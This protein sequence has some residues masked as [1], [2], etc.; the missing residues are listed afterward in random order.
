MIV[1]AVLGVIGAAGWY[2]YRAFSRRNAIAAA[3]Q[4]ADRKEYLQAALAAKRALDFNPKDLSA[5]KLMA[6]MAEAVK[7]REA[8]V[9]RKTVAEMEPGV[10]ENYLQW[11]DTAI[12][13]RDA[14]SAR[15]ALSKMDAA[16]KNTSA[17]HDMAARLA[18]LAGQTRDVQGHVAEAARLDPKNESYQLQLAAVQLGSPL[19]EVRKAATATVEQL[20]ESPKVRRAALRVLVQSSLAANEPNTALKFAYRL[21]TGPDG[22]FEDRMLTLKILGMLQ[23]PE[24]W[25]FIGQ[26]GADLPENDED[27]VT[28]LSWLNNNRLPHLSLKWIGELPSDRV[29]RVPVCVAVAEAHALLGNWSKLKSVLKFQKWGELEFQREALVARVTR[30]EG[31]EAGSHSHW[32]AAV[33]LAAERRD[34]HAALARFA[35]AWKWE[36]EYTNLL[37]VIAKG[38]ND[39]MMALQKLLQKY[40]A[41]G[42]TREL[43]SVFNRMLELEPQNLNTKN[44]VAYALLILNMEPERAHMLANE[45]RSSDPSNSEFTTTYAL[46][47]HMKGKT[48]LALKAMQTVPEKEL[49]IPATALT[50]AVI[51]AAKGKDEEAREF[52]ALAETGTLVPQEKTILLK[53]KDRLPRKP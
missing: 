26:L 25:W 30:E 21:M 3:R 28:L 24:Y 31:D 5:N 18:V 42:N 6:E 17:Y 13:F 20:A 14:A 36:E 40:H 12:R 49:R 23:R 32:N 9:W 44:N 48:D 45:I 51:L 10:A 2:G 50:Y 41:D 7:T 43:L 29:E 53:T 37:W 16:G 8:V 34:A 4:F 33:T 39:P 47:Q 46:S 38:R 52:L 15:E 1:V 19:P 27:L 35:V 22:V 11:A